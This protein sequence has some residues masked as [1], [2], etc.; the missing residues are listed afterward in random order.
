MDFWEVPLAMIRAGGSHLLGF[1]RVERRRGSVGGD[2]L[3]L[4][5]TGGVAGETGRLRT[6]A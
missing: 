3:R 4:R 6:A 5:V 2:V 1:L